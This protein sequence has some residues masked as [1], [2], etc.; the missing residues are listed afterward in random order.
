M[1]VEYNDDGYLISLQITYEN[2]DKKSLDYLASHIP[3][4][5]DHVE[6]YR[7]MKNVKVSEIPFDTSFERF[8]DDYAVKAGN[9]Q[10]SMRLWKALSEDNRIKAIKHISMYDQFLLQNEG[11]QKKLPETYLNQQQ[12]NN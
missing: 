1:I 11:R 4:L 12:W 3:S 10:R 8:W 2:M 9:K 5:V 7:K 6:F